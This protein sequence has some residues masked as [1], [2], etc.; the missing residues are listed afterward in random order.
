MTT[1]PTSLKMRRDFDYVAMDDYEADME[2][3]AKLASGIISKLKRECDDFRYR[4]WLVVNANGGSLSFHESDVLEN[5]PQDCELEFSW[6]PASDLFT[7]TAKRA[8][9]LSKR[10]E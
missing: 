1:E 2:E 8:R 10:Q 4:L 3:Q 6:A 9:T 5:S 7:V